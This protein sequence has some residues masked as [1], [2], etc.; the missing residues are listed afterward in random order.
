MDGD[1][2]AFCLQIQKLEPP[3]VASQTVPQNSGPQELSFD[4]G[5]FGISSTDS[6][7]EPPCTI[8]LWPAIVI[9][10]A[11]ILTDPTKHDNRVIQQ[12]T[13]QLVDIVEQ[14]N[15]L[16]ELLDEERKR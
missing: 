4:L 5:R 16:V 7:F 12:K 13:K 3:R 15:A 2:Y 8:C 10:L 11:L 1:S 6:K 14:R 9:Q